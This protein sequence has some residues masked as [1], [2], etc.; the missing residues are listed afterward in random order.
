MWESTPFA[1]LVRDALGQ[2]GMTLRRLAEAAVDP[3]TKQSLGHNQLWKIGQGQP[4]KVL[5]WIVRAVAA[6]TGKDVREVQLAAAEQYVG[7]T[8]GD[9]LGMGGESAAVVVAHV[10]GIRPADLPKVQELLRN[11]AADASRTGN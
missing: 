5:P 3:Q 11:W 2:N 6:A 9:P 8:A 10:P 4:V 1:D 7:L